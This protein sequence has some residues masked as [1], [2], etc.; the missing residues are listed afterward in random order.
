MEICPKQLAWVQDQDVCMF[1]N[2]PKG[3]SLTSYVCMDSK[4]GY[5]SCFACESKLEEAVKKWYEYYDINYLKNKDIKI[6]RSSGEIESGWRFLNPTSI[7]C[8]D[9]QNMK[10]YCLNEIQE[11]TKWCRIDDILKLNPREDLR[12][13]CV[14][15][16]IDMGEDNPR[17]LC[18]KSYCP[19]EEGEN[20][21]K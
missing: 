9:A 1:C 12:N 6:K 17:Q 13:L 8:D 5:I 21:N 15:C 14:N 16:G 18:C 19:N 2:N 4:L 7:N 3:S 11:L 10:I 20:L